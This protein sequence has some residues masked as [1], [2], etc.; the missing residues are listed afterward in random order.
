MAPEPTVPSAAPSRPATTTRSPSATSSSSST[1]PTPSTPPERAEPLV[2]RPGDEG[3]EVTELQQRLSQ[4]GLYAGNA[5]GDY[6]TRTETSVRN[7]QV[8][9]NISEEAGVY[10]KETRR[11]LESETAE[12]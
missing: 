2:L 8:T 10:G 11:R 1:R 3:P 12:P 6:D 7:F 4:S 5:T 9:R